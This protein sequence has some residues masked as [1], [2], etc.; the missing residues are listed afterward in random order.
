MLAGSGIEV[1]AQRDEI[2]QVLLGS[3]GYKT[4]NL[5]GNRCQKKTPSSRPPWHVL[6]LVALVANVPASSQPE[7][8]I[9]SSVEPYK[10]RRS[11]E[12][13]CNRIS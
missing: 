9:Q 1:R 12:V 6:S 10:V 4:A 3:T 2:T 8:G 5:P 11:A 13:P 7:P